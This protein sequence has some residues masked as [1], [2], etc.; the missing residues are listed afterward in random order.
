[1]RT[2]D[3]DGWLTTADEQECWAEYCR[4]MNLNAADP[5]ADE[6]LALEY[7][8]RVFAALDPVQYAR[9]QADAD[10]ASYGYK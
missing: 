5:L 7:W 1:M 3:V 9:R 10:A 2:F 6:A 4:S 8:E